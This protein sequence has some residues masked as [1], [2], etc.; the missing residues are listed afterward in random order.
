M[1]DSKI[2]LE[3]KLSMQISTS[4][5]Q[6]NMLKNICSKLW[7]DHFPVGS[8]ICWNNEGLSTISI[9]LLSVMLLSCNTIT[10]LSPHIVSCFK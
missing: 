4:M 3:L 6:L 8:Y 1:G 7:V 10:D 5:T 9:L 2:A